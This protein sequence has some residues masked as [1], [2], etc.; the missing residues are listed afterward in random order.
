MVN[1]K[2]NSK[3]SQKAKVTR[4]MATKQKLKAKVIERKTLGCSRCKLSKP[5]SDFNKNRVAVHREG[6]SQWCKTCTSDYSKSK[7]DGAKAT[8]IIS[9]K[10]NIS[11]QQKKINSSLLYCSKCKESKILEDFHRCSAAKI[12][13]GRAY[14]CKKCMS[15]HSKQATTVPEKYA[16]KMAPIA[17]DNYKKKRIAPVEAIKPAFFRQPTC[18]DHLL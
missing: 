5:I 11:T 7:R 16:H 9:P 4:K 6:R 3:I 15:L 14:W 12:R 13:N 8:A 1:R 10:K 18:P 17:C 2:T